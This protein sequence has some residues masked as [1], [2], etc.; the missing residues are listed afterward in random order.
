MPFQDVDDEQAVVVPRAPGSVERVLRRI[1]VEDL[2]LKLLALLITLVM[3]FAVTG[4]NKPV[5]I[6][7]A[8]QL[9][10]ILPPNLA[11]GNDPPKTV[12]VY[13]TGRKSKLDGIRASDL[14]AT[15]NLSDS[16]AG[17]RV[18]RLSSDRVSIQLPE[19][20]KLESF[21][22]NT[23]S[24]RLEP[25]T[26]RQIPVDVRLDGKP[27]EG[28]EVY[29]VQATPGIIKVHGPESHLAQL[30]NVPTETISVSG[31]KDSFS[32][33][34]VAIDISDQ[35]VE[36]MNLDVDVTIEIGEKRIDKLFEHVAVQS[37]AGTNRKPVSATVIL[38]GP[39]KVLNQLRSEE[40]KI[41]FN[42]DGTGANSVR[43]ELP[44]GID[45]QVKVVST[46]LP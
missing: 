32:M 5:T 12:E 45:Q 19:G 37:N 13:L 23:V 7:S 18:I 42:K 8:V 44:P 20:V 40:I 36:G 22:P 43:V 24:T 27:A 25:R 6:G 34:N 33:S 46:S 21:K 2:G 4:E 11:I 10:F 41:V 3:W 17:E 35:K 38:K 30:Q 28:F 1:F 29:G 15:V 16:S 26:E 31:R 9:N 39:P 14:V